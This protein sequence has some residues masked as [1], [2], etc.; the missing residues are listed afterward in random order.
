MWGVYCENAD[1]KDNYAWDIA[2]MMLMLVDYGNMMYIL[3]WPS[4]ES[5]VGY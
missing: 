2:M 3:R 4:W 5:E 1:V